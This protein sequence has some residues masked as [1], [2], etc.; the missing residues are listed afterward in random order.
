M[1]SLIYLQPYAPIIFFFFLSPYLSL[2]I[3]D[4]SSHLA[5]NCIGIVLVDVYETMSGFF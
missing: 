2:F 1:N 3:K 4:M 5:L